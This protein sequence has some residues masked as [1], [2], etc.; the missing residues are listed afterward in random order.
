LLAA[1][2]MEGRKETP[3]GQAAAEERK[4]K[5]EAV[6]GK[7]EEMERKRGTTPEF[8]SYV[9]R[10]RDLPIMNLLNRDFLEVLNFSPIAEVAER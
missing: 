8:L 2:V 3:K 9:P 10:V 5:P 4:P 6:K 1:K 7:P